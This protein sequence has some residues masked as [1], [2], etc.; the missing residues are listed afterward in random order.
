M[1]ITTIGYGQLVNTGDYTNQRAYAE[2]IIQDGED[3][4]DCYNSLRNWVRAQ[5][6]AWHT[7][8]SS[9]E[10]LRD[11]QRQLVYKRDQIAAEVTAMRETWDRASAWLTSLGIDP[12]HAIR[13][14]D[15]MPF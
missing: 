4:T 5:L 10:E 12:T 6:G 8:E 15:D 9:L 14:Y 1:R 2:A 13:N 3:P 11:E 7:L